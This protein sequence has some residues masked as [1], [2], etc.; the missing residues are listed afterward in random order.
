[1]HAQLKDALCVRIETEMKGTDATGECM[2]LPAY[3]HC[4]N[5]FCPVVSESP[6]LHRQQQQLLKII[7]TLKGAHQKADL[8][9]EK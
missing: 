1:M 4:I 5:H 6:N 9:S 3:T 7:K 8:Y 2:P